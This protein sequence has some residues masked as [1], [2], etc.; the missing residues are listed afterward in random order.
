MAVKNIVFDMGGVLVE[1][2]PDGMLGRHFPKE[3][4]ELIKKETFRS[5]EWQE[6][7]RGTIE[8]E[9]AVE[10]MCSRLPEELR[11]EAAKMILDR[12]VEM[13]PIEK[14]CP[15][16]EA[17][18]KAG[19]KIYMLSNC[20][21]WLYGFG[22]NVPAFRFFDGFVVSAE[23]KQ[24][25]PEEDIYFTLFKKFDLVP[26]ECFFID[27]SAK[28]VE[29]GIRLGMK[30]HCFADKDVGKLKDALLNEGIII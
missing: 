13:P 26:S 8:V 11:A 2:D 7:D 20:P 24:I 4:H 18:S 3:L 29:T 27:D 30:A 15:V 14:M 6:M 5:P 28:N 25:K 1:F 23:Y 16:V 12:N 19:Y 17:L 9:D 10:I 21:K 22:K